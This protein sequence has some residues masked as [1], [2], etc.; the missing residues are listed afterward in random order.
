MTDG[1]AAPRLV[2]VV[3][4]ARRRGG[5]DV[6]LDQLL[7]YLGAALHKPVVVFESDG[8]LAQRAQN[9]GCV[10]EVLP[11]KEGHGTE[12]GVG[13]V[14]PL[15]EVLA[16]HEPAVTVF[17]SSRAQLYGSRAHQLAG[18]S[19]RTAWVQHVMPSTFWL[20][21]EASSQPTDVVICVSHAVQQ[22][23]HELYPLYPTR[24]VHP[25]VDGPEGPAQFRDPHVRP[26]VGVV[27]RIE[28]W[29]GQDV[30]IKAMS[31]LAERGTAAQ[32][33]LVGQ[34]QSPTWPEF[35]EQIESLVGELGMVDH[36]TFTDHREDVPAL[37]ADLDVFVCASREEGFGLAIV[38]AMSVG[39]PVVATR[40]GGPI[41]I[42]DHGVNGLLVPV[43]DPIALAEAVEQLLQDRAMAERFTEN[44][45][46]T[47]L[48]R[49]TSKRSA[50]SL[51]SLVAELADR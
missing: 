21:R 13:L 35:G 9:S 26:K 40:C 42:V 43:E 34:R 25:G 6:W 36:V 15:A 22:R 24:V 20:H 11:R 18:C 33:T 41:D 14:G 44:A 47:W 30:A 49:F 39:V 37:L 19:G 29:K 12:D 4:S 45:Q 32:L 28:P 16:R 23:Q 5:G 7:P 51:L 31:K 46:R 8:E 2:V 48:Q 27:G 38:E 50:G 1:A 10:A 17:W 3:P